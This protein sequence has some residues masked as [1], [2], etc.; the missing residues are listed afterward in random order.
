MSPR[1]IR[2][3]TELERLKGTADFCHP[4]IQDELQTL[5]EDMA[6]HLIELEDAE[7]GEDA[8]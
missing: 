2:L 3:R 6:A 7:P 4:E 8:D 1:I 5:I